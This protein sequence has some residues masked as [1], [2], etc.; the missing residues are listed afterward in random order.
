MSHAEISARHHR[1][2]PLPGD[3]LALAVAAWRDAARSG[4]E[5]PA[6]REAVAALL[7]P[8]EAEIVRRTPGAAVEVTRET[9]RL[10]Y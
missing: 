10:V 3:R 2:R 6:H 4:S 7:P 5:T 1:E 8:A 9:V